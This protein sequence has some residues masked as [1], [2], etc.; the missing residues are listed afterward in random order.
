[1]I[2]T[3]GT[4]KRQP[5]EGE[6]GVG[7]HIVQLIVSCR[8]EL[9]FGDLSRER[10]GTQKARCHVCE[11]IVGLDF[12]ASDLPA[13]EVIV[14]QVAVECSNHKV[15]IMECVLTIIIVF[16][17][18]TLGEAS[19]VQPMSSPA[20]SEVS[21]SEQAIDQLPVSFDAFVFDG[22]LDFDLVRWKAD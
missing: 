20:F 11:R 15:S 12:I 10:T 1:M 8:F 21:R 6:S 17:T 14:G 9:R 19:H 16:V 3:A 22:L 7:D 5:K 13:D 18:G 4:T 2:V